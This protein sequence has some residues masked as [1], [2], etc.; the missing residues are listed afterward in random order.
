MRDDL[1]KTVPL[2]RSWSRLLRYLSKDRRGAAELAPF[3]AETARREIGVDAVVGGI[4][5]IGLINKHE[6]HRDL[7]TDGAESMELALRQ[8]E[9]RA[10]S[11]ST[12]NACEIARGVL[13]THG[14]NADFLPRVLEAACTNYVHDHIEHVS[15]RVAQTHTVAEAAQ[16]KRSFLNALKVCDFTTQ[17]IFP[18]PRKEKNFRALLET[19]LQLTQ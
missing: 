9:A 17:P 6:S 15:A 3:I 1:H 14:L 10:R 8:F 18:A 7:F 12:R 16:V 13:S 5:L 4:T 11:P 19:E 2:S